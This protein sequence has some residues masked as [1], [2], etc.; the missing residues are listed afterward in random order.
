MNFIITSFILIFLTFLGIIVIRGLNLIE[1]LILTLGISFGLGIA[2]VTSELYVYSRIGIEWSRFNVLLLPILVIAVIL[3]KYKRNFT[4][5]R[6]FRLKLKNVELFLITCIFLVIVY[7]FFE[8]LIRPLT[9]WDSWAI[10]MLKSKVFFTDG[11]ISPQILDYLKSDYPLLFS[12][13]G[14]FIYIMLGKVDDSAVLLLSA[15]FYLFLIITFFAIM[16]KEV[17]LKN[18]LF[19]TFLL[20]SVQTLIRNGGRLEAG[21]ADLPLAYY[22]FATFSLVLNYFDKKS[23]K[24]LIIAVV[25]LSVT[26]LIKFEGIPV[27]II[28]NLFLLYNIILFKKYK[29]L[30]I[31]FSSLIPIFD[32]EFFKRASH[33]EVSY[34][35]AHPLTFSLRKT[36]ISMSGVFLELINLKSWAF[37]WIMYFCGVL[38]K[39]KNNLKLLTADT[40]VIFQLLIYVLIYIFTQA[41]SPESSIERLLIHIAPIAMYSIIIRLKLIKKLPI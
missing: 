32:W 20:A 9:T 28:F 25:I 40:I 10:W 16:K 11:W 22:I 15:F 6:L 34:F 37:L 8:G 24:A 38:I 19:F 36:L 14:T 26:P 21:Q 27:F 5:I 13:S 35:Y 41:N 23:V 33:I 39:V 1:D 2:I 3:L 30:I 12:L 31:I 18:A 7:T 29:H 17:G 4:N